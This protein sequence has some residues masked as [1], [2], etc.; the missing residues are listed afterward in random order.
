MRHNLAS[1]AIVANLALLPTWSWAQTASPLAATLALAQEGRVD[2]ARAW[3]RQLESTT[4]PTD[5]LYPG[6]LYNQG[7]L[8]PDAT[9]ARRLFQR[10]VVEHPL[11]PWSGESVIRLA[12][13]DYASGDPAA[14]LRQL[15]RFR[16]DY[17]ASPLFPV[18][19]VW[20][21]RAAFGAKDSASACK[22]IADGLGRTPA[23]VIATELTTLNRGCVPSAAVA[24]SPSPP[25]SSP[26]S[27]RA[28]RIQV[29]AAPTESAA[30]QVLARAKAAGLTGV[31]VQEKGYWK[32]RLGSYASRTEALAALSTVKSKLG[33]DPFVVNP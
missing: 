31:I 26:P 29:A 2:S 8:S 3:L 30:K 14:A 15:D 21:A 6:I 16:A 33:G 22:W 1:M 10:V 27:S 32:V 13:L 7:L 17:A 18:A 11:S 19:A 24:S 4:P 25:A 20:G 28:Y 12:Q 5:S 23:D 9:E